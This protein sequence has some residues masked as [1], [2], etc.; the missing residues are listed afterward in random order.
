[1]PPGA[2]RSS[3]IAKR[4]SRAPPTTLTNP[5]RRR[6]PSL[7]ATALLSP[8]TATSQASAPRQ[9]RLSQ[10]IDAMKGDVDERMGGARQVDGLQ[11]MQAKIAVEKEI[12]GL[13]ERRSRPQRQFRARAAVAGARRPQ[14]RDGSR[15]A[16]SVELTAVKSAATDRLGIELDLKPLERHMR[17]A[18]RRSRD[19]QTIPRRVQCHRSMRRPSPP[20]APSSTA[21]YPAPAPSCACAS[22]DTAP[23]TTARK[24]SSHAWMPLS[25][26]AASAEVLEQGKQAA[27]QGRARGRRP[28]CGRWKRGKPSIGPWLISRAS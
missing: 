1:M 8:S 10:R 21:W 9:A 15:R 18:C 26:K 7:A 16:L 14:A 2:C 24:P 3:C 22:P 28:G 11:Q 25:R 23:T 19:Y 13:P 20:T 4:P 27:A 17:R 5:R 6:E 12:S